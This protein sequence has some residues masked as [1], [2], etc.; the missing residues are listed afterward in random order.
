[1]TIPSRTVAAASLCLAL[2][3][4]HLPLRALDP[5][6]TVTQYAHDTWTTQTGLPQNSVWAV[7]ETRDG[8][9]WI[10]TQE[11]LVRFD[12]LRFTVFD[13]ENTPVFK[14][15][16]V[17][18]LTEGRDGS[19]WVGTR[20]AGVLRFSAGR[21]QAF[22]VQE[23]LADNVV[24]SL[25]PDSGGGLWVISEGGLSS[26]RDGRALSYPGV[27]GLTG[28]QV[29]SLVEDGKGG[30][31]VGTAVGLR[32]M[33]DG[34][35]VNIALPGGLCGASIRALSRDKAGALWVVTDEGI[36]RWDGTALACVLKESLGPL[37]IKSCLADGSGALWIASQKG[38]LRY[39]D[40]KLR[41]FTAADGVPNDDIRILLEDRQGNLWIGTLGGGLLRYDAGE[42]SRLSSAEGFLG[43]QVEVLYEDREGS[44]WVG[45]DDGGLHRLMDGKFTVIGKPEGLSH[46]LVWSI[47][48]DRTGAVWLGTDNG[49]NRLSGGKITSYS[50]KDGLSNTIIEGFCEDEAGDLW[51]GSWGGGVHRM[52]QGKFVPFPHQKE[53][54]SDYVAAL[55]VDR[56]GALWI[57][58]NGKGLRRLKG[59]VLTTYTVQDGLS[60]DK[61]RVIRED[62]SGN[63]WIGTDG[64]LNLFK[65]GKFR[66]YTTKDGLPS[67][68]VYEIYEDGAGTLWLGVVNGGLSRFD[69]RKFTN[70][71]S[72]D[73]LYSDGV[74]SIQEDGQGDLWMTSNKGLFRVSRR[75]LQEFDAGQRKRLDCVSYGPA[76]GMRSFECNGSVQPCTWKTRDGSLWFATTRGAV[77]LRPGPV[78]Q[79]TAPPPVVIESVAS[80][81]KDVDMTRPE[82][83]PA[84]VKEIEF[85]YTAPSLLS[86]DKV[87]FRYTLQ[88]YQSEWVD[89]D[90]GRDR[91]ASYTNL[92][93]GA[94][95]FRVKAANSDG[96]W[97]EEGA[98]WSFRIHAHF[99][100]APWFLTLALLVATAL[101]VMG[102]QWRMRSFAKRQ[103]ELA[104]LVEER[105]REL[106][107]AR[108]QAEGSNRAKTEF[109][110]NMSHE[111]RTPMTA[112]IGFSE[113]LE[114]QFFGPL[115]PKQREHIANILSSAR[116]LLSL[117]N[118]I[119]DLAKVEAGRM[120]LELNQFVP[121]NLLISAMTMVRERAHK[122]GVTLDMVPGAG[123]DWVAEADER[124]IKQILFNLLSNAVKFTP[125]GK[126]VRIGARMTAPHPRGDG[127]PRLI[128]S[129]EDQGIGIR[130]E[131]LPR[132]FKPFTQLESA[133]TKR[134]E[135]TGLGLALTHKLVELHGGQIRVESQVDVGSIFTVEIPVNLPAGWPKEED[136]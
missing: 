42:F 90:R 95:T 92:G 79:S 100:Q 84:S 68:E 127:K 62:R 112:I 49:L 133:Y 71:T 28:N 4:V 102:Y 3:A 65:D 135:G 35:P 130:R 97:S 29:R 113:V 47:Y 101:A 17:T 118:D 59:D 16:E 81:G 51:I 12:G 14:S 24:L 50:K 89:V 23:G 11:G 73:G 129:V 131:D 66:V 67:K 58:T 70:Y 55:S 40:G 53:L 125:K 10:G 116:H 120:E 18:A 128:L 104:L 83:F 52:H 8:Y 21:F 88:G 93:P 7:A 33:R 123:S 48:E 132:L 124:K 134:F 34:R 106:E 99:Y 15:A 77:V 63:L 26:I 114:D 110:S 75:Q 27:A 74:F 94:Y 105:T 111:L 39:A 87:R 31:W 103:R 61:V 98:A 107:E 41:H 36:S 109:L 82:T 96:V 44:L 13:R 119:L 122:Q 78:P 38:L 72:K 25:F 117:I 85:R 6:K 54:S 56:E 60:H 32:A 136:P 2:L 45:T 37:S 69:G 86:P 43:D 108:L 20:G 115:T 22:T 5:A 30:V 1:M 9:L 121:N 76:D 80:D 91:L 126:S 64:G 46:D 19:L 57:G